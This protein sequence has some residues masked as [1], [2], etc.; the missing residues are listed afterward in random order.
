MSAG[1][2]PPAERAG[3]GRRLGSLAYEML[4]AAAIVLLA[5]FATAPV[6]TPAARGVLVVPGFVGR[7][8]GLVIVVAVLG[9]YFVWCW[10]GGR[11]T[12]PMKTWRLRLVRAGDGS[13]VDARA[14][15]VRFAAA[16]AGPALA[17]AVYALTQARTAWVLVACGYLWALV[18]RDRAFLHDRVAGT[19]LVFD[20]AAK[21]AK[22]SA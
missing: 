9:A 14:A 2:R 3:L 10:S 13:G 5:G 16:G 7:A 4:L 22:T 15:V 18:D 21:P 1:P 8:V 6:V 20:P 19:A 12:L 11:R 17:V